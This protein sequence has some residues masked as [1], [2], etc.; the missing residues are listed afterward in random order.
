MTNSLPLFTGETA[1]GDSE[2]FVATGNGTGS[3]QVL[4]G[5]IE[6]YGEFD[7]A[8][9]QLHWK[10]RDGIFY[11]TE[12]DPWTSPDLKYARLNSNTPYKLVISGAGAS[13]NLGATAYNSVIHS[14]S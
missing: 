4:E 9:V 13:T 14:T 10:A 5:M 12:D 8:S 3:S 11:P 7:G 2:I 6:V 1:D